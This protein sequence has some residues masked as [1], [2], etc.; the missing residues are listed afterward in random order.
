MLLSFVLLCLFFNN[1]NK[2][3]IV[4]K[5]SIKNGVMWTDAMHTLSG[6]TGFPVHYQQ[7]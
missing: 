2:K 7:S 4:K 6:D 5:S 3:D 1:N